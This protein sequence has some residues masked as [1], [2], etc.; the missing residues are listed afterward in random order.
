MNYEANTNAIREKAQKIYWTYIR[1]GI[2]RNWRYC[3]REAAI[4][5]GACSSDYDRELLEKKG[6]GHPLI[7]ELSKSSFRFG[8]GILRQSPITPVQDNNEAAA[9][10]DRIAA[11]LERIADHLEATTDWGFDAPAVRTRQ[12]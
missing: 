2:L 12:G 8:D 1:D 6:S 3:V 7:E 11:A 9:V 5:M 10:G 4:C